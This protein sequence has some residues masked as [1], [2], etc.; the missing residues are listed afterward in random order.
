MGYSY[1]TRRRG[2]ELCFSANFWVDVVGDI[3]FRPYKIPDSLT[4]QRYRNFYDKCF[5]GAACRSAFTCEAGVVVAVRR[6]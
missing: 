5:T 6:H 4:A 1:A 3:A 2:C